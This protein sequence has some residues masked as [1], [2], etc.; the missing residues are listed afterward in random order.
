[1]IPP[2]VSGFGCFFL[3]MTSDLY[4]GGRLGARAALASALARNPQ[5][6][7]VLLA[8]RGGKPCLAAVVSANKMITDEAENAFTE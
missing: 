3:V 2:P 1:M 7:P 4:G 8:D 5:C 6:P